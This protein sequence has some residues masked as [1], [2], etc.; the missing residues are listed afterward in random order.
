MFIFMRSLCV[1]QEMVETNHKL[2]VMTMS[3]FLELLLFIRNDV[4][5]HYAATVRIVW[6]T[7]R[8]L[9]VSLCCTTNTKTVESRSE[10]LLYCM[11]LTLKRAEH[12]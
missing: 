10:K 6:A 7:S 5:I 4:M 9:K 8:V 12:L 2:T 11:T 1:I 3:L